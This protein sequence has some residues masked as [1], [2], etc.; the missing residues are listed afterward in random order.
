MAKTWFRIDWNG[1]A[2]GYAAKSA[3]ASKSLQP[4]RMNNT[5]TQQIPVQF[6]RKQTPLAFHAALCSVVLV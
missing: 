4:R 2:G 6:D 1:V 3:D 5:H